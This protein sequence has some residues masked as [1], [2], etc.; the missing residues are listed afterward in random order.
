MAERISQPVEKAL[1]FALLPERFLSKEG[2][3]ITLKPALW[4]LIGNSMQYPKSDEV[5]L[6][7]SKTFFLMAW[8]K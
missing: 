2:T 4:T 5:N 7:E 6:T 3:W 1:T 8:K